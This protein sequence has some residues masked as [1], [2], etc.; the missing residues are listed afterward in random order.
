MDIGGTTFTSCIFNEDL[1]EVISSDI[2]MIAD[3][4][5]KESLL[6]GFAHQGEQLM[7]KSN[8]DISQI[9]GMGV[10]VPGPL[11]AGKG[12]ILDTPNLALLQQTNLKKELESRL[13]IP[14]F[15]ENDANL[16]V[17]G[18]WRRNWLK[19]EK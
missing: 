3:F 11:D 2:G 1:K 17:W 13:N 16:F 4:S 8:I 15:I 9:K 5:D 18:E 12:L 19:F 14:V 7:E 10:S 6:E